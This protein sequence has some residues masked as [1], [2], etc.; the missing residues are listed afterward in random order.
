MY[1]IKCINNYPN[2]KLH[3]LTP[4]DQF[5]FYKYET[6]SRIKKPLSAFKNNILLLRITYTVRAPL[7]ILRVI[8]EFSAKNIMFKANQLS[9]RQGPD[10]F[11][12][13][14]VTKAVAFTGYS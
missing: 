13:V 3:K 2:Y 9:N 14:Q 7:Y 10:R 6:D 5:L 8:F 4:F 11:L 1:D 12:L